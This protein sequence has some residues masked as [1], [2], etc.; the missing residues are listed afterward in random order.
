MFEENLRN[1]WCDG[2]SRR[3]DEI[4]HHFAG[5]DLDESDVLRRIMTGKR[6]SSDTFRLLM[7]K[8][9]KNCKA[10]GYTDELANE[11]C[12]RLKVL[13]DTHFAKHILHLLVVESFQ[14]LYLKSHFPLEFM[15]AVIN[16]FGG[17]YNTELYVSMKHACGAI[18]HAPCVNNSKLSN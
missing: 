7:E 13:V 17:F 5:L 18:I 15:V 8:Y 3:C 6:K 1:I 9:F 16:N 11:V 14:S 10:R 4:V 2:V 12:D